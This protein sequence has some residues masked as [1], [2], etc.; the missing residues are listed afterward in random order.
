M[1]RRALRQMGCVWVVFASAAL[2]AAGPAAG[3]PPSMSAAAQAAHDEMEVLRSQRRVN[4]QPLS[5]V[6]PHYSI[7]GHDEADLVLLNTFSD[8]MQ[9]EVTAVGA[10]GEKT[11][12]GSF[13]VE[14]TQHL[15]L[16]VRELLGGP[17]TP[18]TGSLRVDFQG[19]FDMLQAWA[20]L[21]RGNDV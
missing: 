1:R 4:A 13:T 14:P 2:G 15:A 16:S 10:N 5:L 7:G 12:L 11:P 19:D 18:R 9:A 3:A 20:V 6:A 8:P 21:R 17:P